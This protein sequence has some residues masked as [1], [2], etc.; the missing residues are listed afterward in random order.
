MSKQLN[1]LLI[2]FLGLLMAAGFY[3]LGYFVPRENFWLTFMLFSS[4]FAGMAAVYYLGKA[5]KWSLIFIAGLFFR[6]VLLPATPNWSDDYPRFLWDGE[7]VRMNQN[8]YLDTPE[9]LLQNNPERANSYLNS[10]FETMNSPQYFSVYPPLNQAIFYLAA[11]GAN[12]DAKTGVLIL[13]VILILGEIGVFFLLLKLFDH[14]QLP[15]K[16]LILYWLN[17]LV[18][19]EITGNLHFEGLVLLLLLASLYALS[20]N[21]NLL[22]GGFWGLSVGMKLLPLML[23]PTFFSFQKTRRST[24]FWIGSALALV[25]SFAWLLIDSSW[26]HFLQSLKLYQ[27]KFEFNASVYYLLREVGFWVKGYNVIG[28]ITPILSA[29]TLLGILYF[30]WKKKPQNLLQLIDLW[31]LIYLIYLALHPVV[32]PWYLIPAFGLSLFTSKKAFLIWTFAVIF[33][34]Q[35]YGDPNYQ[36]SPI[37]LFLEYSILALAV[38]WDYFRQKTH[39]K[40]IS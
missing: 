29:V 28:E 23:I 30:S 38:Y 25:L 34:Y 37:F 31:G 3:Y 11:W 27:G 21:R 16:R 39:L 10:L 40:T 8:P 20:K 33:S 32:H 15:E 18:I 1:R 35:A 22:S 5:P 19:M 12:L 14:F 4:L 9:G 24:V 26:V 2:P 6:L 13:R 36:E 7:L 17:P